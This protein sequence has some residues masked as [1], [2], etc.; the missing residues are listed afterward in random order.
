MLTNSDEPYNAQ[1]TP[2]TP[3]SQFHLI[4][5]TPPPNPLASLYSHTSYLVESL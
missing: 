2:S 3:N 5:S 1:S 4:V